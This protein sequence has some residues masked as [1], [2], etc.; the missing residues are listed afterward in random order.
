MPES[1]KLYY[2]ELNKGVAMKMFSRLM[3]LT[4]L[5][6]LVSCAA[7]MKPIK[8]SPKGDL[9]T[10]FSKYRNILN[11]HDWEITQSDADG[12]FLKAVKP[13]TSMGMVVGI[14]ASTISCTQ[15]VNVSCSIKIDECRNTTPLTGCS[16]LTDF[17]ATNEDSL[18]TLIE[19]MNNI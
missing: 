16:P 7:H 14:F 3:L 17:R 8:N 18:K 6:S 4:I 13:F 1:L 5:A 11:R 10:V 19:D 9:R 15:D 12:G 2:G